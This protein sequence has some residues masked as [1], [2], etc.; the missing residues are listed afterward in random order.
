ML[1]EKGISTMIL[2]VSTL[3][4][5]IVLSIINTVILPFAVIVDLFSPEREP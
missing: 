2:V 5:N 1:E 4:T 3:L